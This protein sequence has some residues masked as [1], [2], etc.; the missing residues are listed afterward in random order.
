M[1]RSDAQAL[2]GASA[3]FHRSDQIQIRMPAGYLTIVM[4]RPHFR[5]LQPR[6]L[7]ESSAHIV[8]R[9]EFA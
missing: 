3:Q 7:C 6:Q 1:N 9:E 2:G 8:D 5:V 4:A